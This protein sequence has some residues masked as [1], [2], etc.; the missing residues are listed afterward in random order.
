MGKY[1]LENKTEGNTDKTR[2]CH[3]QNIAYQVQGVFTMSIINVNRL[4]CFIKKAD[5]HL[6]LK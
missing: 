5:Y 1:K 3:Q 4:T 2:K 6:G